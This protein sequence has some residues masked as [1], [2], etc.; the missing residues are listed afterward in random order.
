MS[1]T[2]ITIDDAIDQFHC[3]WP[4]IKD[5]LD[6]NKIDHGPIKE[7]GG[8]F[9]VQISYSQLCKHFPQKDVRQRRISD[10][11]KIGAGAVAGAAVSEVTNAIKRIGSNPEPSDSKTLTKPRGEP[12]NREQTGLYFRFKNFASARAGLGLTQSQFASLSNIDRQLVHQI[13]SGSKLIGWAVLQRVLAVLNPGAVLLDISI[14][15]KSDND[16][17]LGETVKVVKNHLEN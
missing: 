17:R 10:A 15:E 11:V 7:H 4:E 3:S 5:L 12:W 8:L 13:E 14:V 9:L 1:Y 16:R 6:A 2:W